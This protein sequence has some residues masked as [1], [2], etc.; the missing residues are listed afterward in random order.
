MLVNPIM[1]GMNLVAK[2]GPVVNKRGGVLVLSRTAGAFQQ[3]GKFSL[4][5]TST[6]VGDTAEALY[7]ALTMPRY[8]RHALAVQA[9]HTVE[10]QDLHVWLQH[11]INDINDLLHPLPPRILPQKTLYT[12]APAR[13]PGRKKT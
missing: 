3:L 2:E 6:D 5:I 11:Q 1:D 8:E 4:P 13:P 9:R 7:L 12:L 10:I